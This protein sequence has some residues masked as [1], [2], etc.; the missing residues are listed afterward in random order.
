MN[1][2]KLI[3]RARRGWNALRKEIERFGTIDDGAGKRMRIGVDLVRASQ[4]ERALEFYAWRDDLLPDQIDEPLDALAH[5]MAFLRTGDPDRARVMLHRTALAN[6]YLVPAVLGRP[7]EAMD[8]WHG[9][10]FEDAVYIEELREE[11]LDLSEP[12]KAWIAEEYDRPEALALRQT[13]IDERDALKNAQNRNRRSEAMRR[14]RE[15]RRSFFDRLSP[16]D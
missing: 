15:I 9:T 13:W 1:E 6:P 10:N 2:Q 12:E 3:A 14:F 4:P 16:G 7:I 8:V 5:C 11:W